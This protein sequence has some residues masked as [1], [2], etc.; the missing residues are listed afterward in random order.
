MHRGAGL[1]RALGKQPALLEASLLRTRYSSEPGSLTLELAGRTV[2]WCESRACRLK[3]AVGDSANRDTR[4]VAG[5][6]AMVQ[7]TSSHRSTDCASW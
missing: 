4:R 1:V 6:A 3:P 5:T 7:P 2:T